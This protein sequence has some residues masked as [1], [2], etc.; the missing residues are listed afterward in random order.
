MKYFELDKKE[1]QILDDYNQDQFVG[2]TNAKEEKKNL[3]KYAKNTL[4]KARN[5]NIRLTEK[6]LQKI[7][8]KALKE[9]IP[10]QTLIA[11]LIHQGI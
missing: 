10:Y 9:G 7:K 3:Q 4:N 6:D 1:E 11:S 8:T 2:V 5:I